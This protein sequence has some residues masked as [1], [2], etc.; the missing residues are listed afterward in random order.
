MAS[1]NGTLRL[2][3]DAAKACAIV[4]FVNQELDFSNITDE[5]DNWIFAGGQVC[6]KPFPLRLLLVDSLIDNNAILFLAKPK[7]AFSI[8]VDDLN[9]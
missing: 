2:T 1:Q 9:N 4:C 8:I 5:F 3:R 7:S 6:G